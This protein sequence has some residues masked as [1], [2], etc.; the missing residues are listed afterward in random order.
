MTGITVKSWIA[1]DGRPREAPVIHRGHKFL[2]LTGRRAL[3]QGIADTWEEW[4]QR[5]GVSYQRIGNQL[6]VHR[7]HNGRWCCDDR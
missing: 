7:F 4:C 1:E 3:D 5:T 6:Y 2:I